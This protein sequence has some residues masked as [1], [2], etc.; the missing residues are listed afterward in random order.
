M[1]TRARILEQAARLRAGFE[2][3]GAQGVETPILQ[4]AETLLDLYGEDIRARAYVTSDALRGEQMLRPDF[5][6]PVVQKHME[7]GAEPARYTYAGEVFR[8]Q[9]HDPDRANEYIQ[10]GYEVFDRT[11]PAAA[12]A[13]V[14]ALIAQALD[15]LA[16]RAATGDIGILMAAVEGLKTTEPRKAALMRHIWRPRRFRALLDRYAGRT[17][18]PPA[19]AALLA[20]SEPLADGAP[21]IGKRSRAEVE[22]RIEVLRADAAAAPISDNEMAGLDALLSVRET[23]PYALE[24]L[25][26]IAVDLPQITP[27]LDRLEARIA[28]LRA[29]GI[30]VD[31]LDFEASYGR[32]S[33]EYYDG[34]VFGFY[35]ERRP[36]LPPIA[37]GGR[38]DAL[39][40]RLG[41]GA[42]IPAV[43]GVLRPG[44]MLLLAEA[45]T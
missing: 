22:A 3:A 27:A 38:Y 37:T 21:E 5:T 43:G 26:D 11:N 20:E 35:A 16:L 42:E 15:G 41:N 10:V 30:N 31:R 17:T 23:M 40:R 8:R 4:P 39:T 13:E 45:E 28:A 44:L 33:M 19:R 29:R 34:F 1:I 36:D 9:E 12:D 6:V 24:H 7:H 14:F 25:R 32:T 2:A 18:V